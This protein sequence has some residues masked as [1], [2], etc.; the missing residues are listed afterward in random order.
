MLC[1][2]VITNAV[3]DILFVGLI[4]CTLCAVRL[5]SGCRRLGRARRFFGFRDRTEIGI[6]VSGFVHEGVKT[7]RVVNAAEYE[8][9]VE[10]R[11]ALQELA[12]RGLVRTFADYLAGLIGFDPRYP[13]PHVKVSPLEEVRTLTCRGSLILIGG[14]VANQ[15]TK[16]YLQDSPR[17][18]F[19]EKTRTY[20]ER[21]EDGYQVIEHSDDVAIIERRLVGTQ[22]V[23]LVHGFSE[24][25]TIRAAQ[26]LSDHWETLYK[27]HDAREFGM[28][29]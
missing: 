23:I 24:E 28:R 20:E 3:S 11:S 9:A 15:V 26:H 2:D 8:A 27:Q 25:Q 6:Y 29:V 4:T 18:R 12:G 13:E 7:K 22:V 14:P 5:V 1:W 21:D 16:F 17:F 10:V 19:N